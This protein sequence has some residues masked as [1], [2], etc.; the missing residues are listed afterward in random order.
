VVLIDDCLH[1]SFKQKRRNLH[2]AR[3]CLFCELFKLLERLR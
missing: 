3:L 2:G 1:R